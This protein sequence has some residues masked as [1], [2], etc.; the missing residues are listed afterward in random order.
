MRR[1]RMLVPFSKME[2]A[3]SI[4]RQAVAT[5]TV[6]DPQQTLHGTCGFSA[7]MESHPVVNPKRYRRRRNSPDWPGE[8]GV[9]TG[10]ETGYYVKPI[11]ADV[12]NDMRIAR[13]EIFGPVLC[14]IGYKDFR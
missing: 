6:G 14:I 3:K 5:I 9:Q 13:E 1:H 4:A 11:F 10:F 12:M 2:A 8:R 7:A